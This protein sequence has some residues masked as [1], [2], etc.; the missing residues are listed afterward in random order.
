MAVLKRDISDALLAEMSK[1]VWHPIMLVDL[2]WPGERLRAHSG[3]GPI[4]W[5]GETWNGVGKFGAVSSPTEGT[6]L[7]ASSITM[8]L[9][10]LP[11][12][13]LDEAMQ[14]IRNREALVYLGATTSPAG[15]VL[16]GNPYLLIAGYMD[17]LR[18]T[19]QRD[20]E[21]L[22]HGLQ[23]DI[24]IGPSARSAAVVL[25][26]AEDQGAKYPGDTAGRH[27]IEIEKRLQVMT[28]PED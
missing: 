26:S 8:Q 25:H 28:W 6:G 18:F 4:V 7:A 22:Q 15:S 11:P 27:L 16:I 5:K 1:S 23:L 24:G 12:E 10:G 3:V 2:D 20:G 19:T 21:D 13:V 17:A 9:M 14:P